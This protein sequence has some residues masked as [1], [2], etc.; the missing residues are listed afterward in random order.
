MR[1]AVEFTMRVSRLSMILAI[2]PVCTALV[3]AASPGVDVEENRKLLREWQV[4]QPSE[5]QRIR[6]NYDRFRALPE[7]RRERIRQLDRDLHRQPAAA[8]RLGRVLDEYSVWLTRLPAGDRE[9]IESAATTKEK[10]RIIRELKERQWYQRLPRAYQEQYTTAKTDKERQELIGQWRQRERELQSQWAETRF[11]WAAVP[12][13]RPMMLFLQPAFWKDLSEFARLKLD[14]M[15]DPFERN[16]L[17]RAVQEFDRGNNVASAGILLRTMHDLSERHPVLSLEPKYKT[18][19]ALPPD[20]QRALRRLPKFALRKLP[21][22]RWPEYA[23]EVT[24]LLR[25]SRMQ[26]AEQL[27]PATAREISEKVDAWVQKALWPKLTDS[28]KA[29]L[30]SAEGKWPDYPQ[31]LH[32]AAKAHRLAIPELS[33]P[34]DPRTGD[35]RMW[36]MLKQRPMPGRKP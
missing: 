31:A 4:N 29:Q 17:E 6:R 36:D 11:F 8:E 33:L 14:P 27:G 10:L 3:L 13:R 25:K 28:Q 12:N 35:T 20:Y 22:G 9:R 19:Q 2:G 1:A 15:L 21:E 5:Y 32:E 34:G 23:V 7:E 26:P 16:R 18:F 30:K 24:Q